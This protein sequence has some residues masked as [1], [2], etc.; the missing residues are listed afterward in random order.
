MSSSLEGSIEWERL[1]WSVFDG[2]KNPIALSDEHRVYL[3]ANPAMCEFFGAPKEDLVGRP[4]DRSLAPQERPR[5]DA[6]WAELWR[7]NDWHGVRDAVRADG[8]RMHVEVAARTAKIAGRSVAIVV[9]L[10]A[11]REGE[12]ARSVRS[13]ELTPREREV[14]S[15]LA[16]GLTSGEIAERLVLSPA[17]ARTHVQNA[18]TKAGAKTRAQLVAIALADRHILHVR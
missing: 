6:D 11:E 5:L 13:G 3:A 9:Y 14:V 4:L 8:S 7:R 2:S 16:L 15:L 10:V 1:F 17:T 18:M 12:P